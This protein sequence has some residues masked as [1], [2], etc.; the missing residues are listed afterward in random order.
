MKVVIF[1]ITSKLFTSCTVILSTFP[2]TS[3]CMQF[4]QYPQHAY[5]ATNT[6]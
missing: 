6:P 3:A 5:S 1:K 4:L 2:P